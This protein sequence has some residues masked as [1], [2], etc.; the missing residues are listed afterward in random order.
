MNP[1]DKMPVSTDTGPQQPQVTPEEV[2]E[3][4]TEIT[5]N[6][7]QERAELA[8]EMPP[9]VDNIESASGDDSSPEA[10][11]NPEQ[12]EGAPSN[13]PINSIETMI[14]DAGGPNKYTEMVM[15]YAN[16]L[17]PE[18]LEHPLFKTILVFAAKYGGLFD[19]LSNMGLGFD[20]ILNKEEYKNEKLQENEA[21][22]LKNFPEMIDLS[23]INFDKSQSEAVESASARLA[24]NILFAN[25]DNGISLSQSNIK[26][27][28][29]LAKKLRDGYT[30]HADNGQEFNKDYLLANYTN[31][32][33]GSVMFFQVKKEQKDGGIGSFIKSTFSGVFD[34]KGN[35]V[36]YG[37]DKNSDTPSVKT[38]PISDL[39]G[40]E[41]IIS[42]IYKKDLNKLNQV[43]D[44]TVAE[45]SVP[46]ENAPATAPSEPTAT[47][48]SEPTASQTPSTVENA[49]APAPTVNPAPTSTPE[50]EANGTIQ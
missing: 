42:K 50:E 18:M 9:S 23:Q 5:D 2:Q 12:T 7:T 45:T 39:Q 43:T 34:G 37:L 35:I 13:L 40:S 29:Q 10:T 47:A 21:N 38:V 24:S 19:S 33:A 17:P 15:Q 32:P 26:D 14:N 49:P 22:I 20:D 11:Q 30:S 3:Q 27:P 36:Y 25:H 46:D 16:N 41:Y 1:I 44:G 48:P 28:Y 8:G 31:F 4:R 6:S